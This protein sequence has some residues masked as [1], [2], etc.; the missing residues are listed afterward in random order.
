MAQS[1]LTV[2]TPNPTPPTNFSST[3]ATPPNPPNFTRQTMNDPKN[4]SATNPKDFPPPYDDGSAGALATFAPTLRRW[5][6]APRRPTTTPAPRRARRVQ[7]RAAPGLTA[8][9]GLIRARLAVWC[10]LRAVSRT[11]ALALRPRLPS[12]IRRRSWRQSRW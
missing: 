8:R 6:R 3:G 7:A 10:R 5:R 2:T 9:S 4:W 11:R 12:L 1:A